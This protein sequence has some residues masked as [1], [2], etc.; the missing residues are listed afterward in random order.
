MIEKLLAGR[1]TLKAAILIISLTA[2]VYANT[3]GNSFVWDDHLVIVNNN[4][5]KSWKNLPQV[6]TKRYITSPADDDFLGLRDIG[7]GE[8]SYRPLVTISYFIDYA[9]WKLNPFG[10]HLTNLALHI[11]NSLLLYALFLLITKN[12]G[13]SLL[14][15]L[16]F[17]LHPVNAEAVG[18]ISFREDLL[19]FLFF[20]SSLVF[21]IKFSTYP[22]AGGI[23]RYIFS[24]F[25]FLP[26][27]FS[28]ESAVILPCIIVLYD[29][30]FVCGQKVRQLPRF[31]YRYAGYIMVLLLYLWLW[32]F[33]FKGHIGIGGA[34][35]NFYK[36]GI[37]S[38]LPVISEA[39]TTYLGW[40]IF[41]INIHVVLYREYPPLIFIPKII[42]S[43]LFISISFLYALRIRRSSRGLCFSMGWFYIALLP[44]SNIF[45]LF[46][47]I[48]SRYLYLPA[49]GFCLFAAIFLLSAGDFGTGLVS[50]D[51]L[52]KFSRSAI[53]ILLVFYSMF[54][55]IR[56]ISCNNDVIFWSE[57]ARNYPDLSI[58]R[59]NLGLALA[60]AGFVDEGIEEC[61]VAVKLAPDDAMNRLR[62]GLCYYIKGDVDKA[63]PELKAALKLKP[64]LLRAYIY[65]GTCFMKKKSYEEAAACARHVIKK[66]PRS[67]AAYNMLGVV[68]AGMKKYDQAQ[69]IWEEGLGINPDADQIKENLRK[70]RSSRLKTGS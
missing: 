62:L 8:A 65:L 20:V 18:V 69:K 36:G 24:L 60:E 31:K 23:K 10:Y 15:S 30:F 63:V 28:K 44:V 34:L 40:L 35:S 11:F 47:P 39:F 52:R 56:N 4:F 43:A 22:G 21:Y 27:L 41:P 45:A 51:F 16:F 70:L 42:F 55:V 7:S 61:R 25:L 33:Y 2:A 58:T 53:I 12:R 48:A 17:A 32:D 26:A 13:A 67:I 57:A 29:Y 38:S 50:G 5:I 37:Y 14:A 64:D 46:M 3:L 1:S 68:Y 49:A 6:F 19:A 9:V 59:G 66:S 54:T